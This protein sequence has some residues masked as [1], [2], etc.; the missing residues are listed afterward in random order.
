MTNPES[1]EL[2]L[3]PLGVVLFP[4][5]VLPLR[6]FEERYKLM[7][8]HCLE[9]DSSF[10][11]ALI[12]SG[13]EVGAPAVPYDVGTLAKIIDVTPQPEGRMNLITMGDTPFRILK[14]EQ[15]SPYIV[16]RV[17][18]LDRPRDD[19]EEMKELAAS[20]RKH[21]GTY[22]ALY[23]SLTE[24]EPKE[25]RLEDDPDKLSYLVA[26]AMRTDSRRKQ[27]LLEISS[28]EERI[29]EEL[30]LLEQEN[31]AL[32]LFLTQKQSGQGET[33]SGEGPLKRRFSPN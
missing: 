6:I 3:F 19:S 14:I 29:R 25:V 10:G 27:K 22:I 2:P 30:T 21:F 24:N 16:G 33:D 18:M 4:G 5:M 20:L 8:K 31:L 32:R 1:R 9:G 23:S 13:K 17:E 7:L 11:V 28:A 26:S 12:R 15:N